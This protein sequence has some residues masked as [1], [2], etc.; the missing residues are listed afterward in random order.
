MD[1]LA[2]GILVVFY[3]FGVVPTIGSMFT[4]DLGSYYMD[5]M[6]LGIVVHAVLG[7]T[8]IV[9]ASVFWALYQVTS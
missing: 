1:I 4:S 2:W 6:K 8:V 9:L 7:G 5:D 3:V